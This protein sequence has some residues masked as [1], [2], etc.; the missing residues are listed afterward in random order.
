MKEGQFSLDIRK[1]FFTVRWARHWNRLPREAVD[2]TILAVIKTR[3][4]K[5]L[6][7]VVSWEVSLPMA[8]SLGLDSFQVHSNPL[9]LHDSK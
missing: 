5:A 3:L 8:E 1:K 9:T 7:S 2:A 6:G 4:D